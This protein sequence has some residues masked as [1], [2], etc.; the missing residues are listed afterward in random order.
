M[1]G[2]TLIELLVSTVIM[3][4]IIAALFM[5]MNAGQRAWFGGDTSVELRAQAIG[6]IT[7]MN[8]E[9]SKTRPSRT[10][11]DIGEQANSVTFS[12]PQDNSG[13]GSVV[14]AAGTIEWSPNITYSLNANQII[15]ASG[16]ITRVLAVDIS[17]LRFTRTQDKI[18]QIDIT[19]Q[20][21][22]QDGRQLQDIEQVIIKMRN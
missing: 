11:L 10:D 3:T 2:L 6:A 5:A 21:T 1:K 19:A 18:M 8:K 17:L 14:D 20:R 16:G 15:R 9:L 4:I 7:V 13:D 22:T 12:I